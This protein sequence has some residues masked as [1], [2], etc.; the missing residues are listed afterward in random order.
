MRKETYVMCLTKNRMFFQEMKKKM[1]RTPMQNFF[2][3]KIL[4]YLN[5]KPF[6]FKSFLASSIS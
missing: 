3:F 1:I 5:L 4:F 6:V 2:I